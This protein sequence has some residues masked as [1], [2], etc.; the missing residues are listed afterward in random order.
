[1]KANKLASKY[2]YS[3]DLTVVPKN[4]QLSDL[5]INMHKKLHIPSFMFCY[6]CGT[7]APDV[8]WNRL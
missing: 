2:E 5:L 8:E 3:L 1:M 4:A 7:S 6:Q